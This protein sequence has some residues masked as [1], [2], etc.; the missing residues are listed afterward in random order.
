VRTPPLLKDLPE[1]DVRR[2]LEAARR[3]TFAAGEVIVHEGDIADTLHLIVKGRVSVTVMS[4]YGQQLTF[5]LMGPDEFFGE[6]AL[7]GPDSV[8]TATVRALEPTELRSIR[9]TDFDALRRQYPGVNEALI[10]ILAAR[11]ARLSS[12]LQES[13]HVAVETRV[14]RRVIELAQLYGGGAPGTVIPLTQEE[15]AGLAGTARAT[16]NR[17]LRQEEADGNVSLG[18]HRVTVHDLPALIKRAELD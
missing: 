12:R 10:R 2:L 1:D 15:L 11:V 7:L 8:R 6:L 17:V 16:V 9:R 3:R 13:L 18:R 4:R 14:R 5:A